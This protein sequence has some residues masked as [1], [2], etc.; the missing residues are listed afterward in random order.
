MGVVDFACLYQ[1]FDPAVA[2]EA[3]ELL[4]ASDTLDDLLRLSGGHFRS[5]FLLMRTAIETSGLVA[6]L[7]A[8]HVGRV[9]R[10]LASK[11]LEPLRSEERDVLKVVHATRQRPE[12]DGELQCFLD[13]LSD[14]YVFAYVA[15]DRRWYDWNPLLELSSLA[16]P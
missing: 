3:E 10:N 2:L 1:Q 6:P 13:L 8:D 11:Y 14:E 16:L 12:D 9:V 5:L 7:R 4:E 15:G